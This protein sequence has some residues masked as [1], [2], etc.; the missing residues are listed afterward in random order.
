MEKK[1]KKLGRPTKIETID[2]DLVLFLCSK[3]CTNEEIATALKI[4]TST[5]SKYLAENS[6]F[7]DAVRKGRE[8]ADS[9]VEQSLYE[10]ACGFECDEERGV[11]VDGSVEIVKTK[12][13]HAPDTV[14][15]MFWLA[16]R[17]RQKWQHISKIEHTGEGGGPIVIETVSFAHTKR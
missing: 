6:A 10:A 12:K 3:G 11:V 9:K 14:A 7:S 4:A 1:T 16:N 13:K 8:L 17:Q 15:A 2:K 5:F